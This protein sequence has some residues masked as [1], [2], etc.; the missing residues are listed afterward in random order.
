MVPRPH[1]DERVVVNASVQGGNVIKTMNTAKIEKIDGIM[2]VVIFF[3]GLF[4]V[5]G[6]GNVSGS[7]GDT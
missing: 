3:G 5:E 4:I 6:C 2:M 1:T 7:V